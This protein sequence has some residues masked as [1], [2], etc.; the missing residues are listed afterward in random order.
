MKQRKNNRF[1][2]MLMAMLMIVS[3]V[4]TGWYPVVAKADTNT[5][6]TLTVI[7]DTGNHSKNL[8]EHTG[9]VYWL[10]D[11][12]LNIDVNSLE[13]YYVAENCK[14][15]IKAALKEAKIDYHFSDEGSCFPDDMK[16]KDG[17][18]LQSDWSKGYWSVIVQYADGSFNSNG[19]SSYDGAAQLQDGCR[20][21]YY[22]SDNPTNDCRLTT[23]DS[24]NT[25]LNYDTDAVTGLRFSTEEQPDAALTEIE[26]EVGS[27]IDLLTS[28]TAPAQTTVSKALNWTSSN[29]DVATVTASETG[30][31]VTPKSAGTTTVKASM[32]NT[33]GDTVEASCDVKVTSNGTT[34][35]DL[36]FAEGTEISMAPGAV[37]TL[38][39]AYTPE[40]E[41]GETAPALTW[42]SS[43]K[44][45]AD[46]NAQN[47]EITAKTPGTT[48]IKASFTN[49]KGTVVSAECKVTVE[50]IAVTKIAL[51][52]ESLSL[53][54]DAESKLNVTFEPANATEDLDVKWE[55]DDKNVATVT[56]EGKSATV[57][58]VGAGSATITV[59]AGTFKASCEVT[60][61]AAQPMVKEF[62]FA[63]DKNGENVY[64]MQSE[65]DAKTKECT[66]V[67]PETV[68]TFYLKP[69]L[70]DDAEVNTIT[71]NYKN[72]NYTKDLTK[73]MP[74][75]EFTQFSGVN[76]VLQSDI[77]ARE[78]SIDVTSKT[79]KTETYKV[80]IIRETTLSGL[81]VTKADGTKVTLDPVF[82][83]RK[84]EYTI[85]VPKTLESVVFKA[86]ARTAANSEIKVNGKTAE[87]G[88]Y[89]LALTGDDAKVVTE[90]EVGNENTVAGKYTVSI[91]R[92]EPVTITF[93]TEPKDAIITV[94]DK[95][96]IKAGGEDG[97]YKVLP[98]TYTYTV[99]K[100]GYVTKHEEITVEKDTVIKA[101][102]E[103]AQSSNLKDLDCDWAGFRK[104]GSNQAVTSAK[105]AATPETA[106]QK[107]EKKVGE[108]F[109]NWAVSSPIIVDNNL[110]CYAGKQL[111][112]INKETG[113]I[114]ASAPMAGNSSFGINPPCYGGGMIFVGL[115]GGAV[116]AFNAETLESLWVFKD[117]LGGQPNCTI[118]YSDGYIYTGFWNSETKDANFVCVSAT[119][120]DP[121]NTTETKY[122]TWTYAVQGG[123]Y[124][125]GAYVTDKYAIVGSDDGE[126]DSTSDS[127][128]VY[129]FDKL[130]GEVVQK[131]GP[132]HGDIRS[133]I[134]YYDGRIYF[135]S[136]GG[137]LYSYNLKEDGTIDTENLI[138]PIEIGKMST[139]TPAIANG[140][141]Y[142]GS[143]YGSN[144]SGTYGISVVDINAETGAM[145]LE[146]VVYTDAY[147]QTSGVVSTGYK[148]YNYVYF[149][150]N[151]PSGNLWV[152]KDAP[153]M[154]EP[155]EGSQ[156]LYTP[157]HKQ[158]C[159][160]SVAVDKDGTIYFKNDSAYMIAVG[161]SAIDTDKL[162]DLIETAKATDASKYT[163]ESYNALQD[164][165]AEAEA[166]AENPES[167]EQVAEMTEK[168]QSA[169]DGLVVK[170][171]WQ[172]I[173]GKKYYYKEDGIQATY[174]YKVDG[175]YYWF[176]TDGIMKTYWQKV[177]NKYY[178]LGSDGAMRTGWQTVYGK[179]YYLG[180]ANDG[181]M[182]TGWQTVDGK[183]YYLGNASDGAMKTGWQTIDGKKYYLGNDGAM[184]TYWQSVDGKYYWFGTDGVMKTYWQKVYNK[185]YWLG[186]DGAMRTGWQKVYGKYYW[187]GHSNDGAMKTGWQ[188]IYGKKYYFGGANDG[189]MKTGWQKIGG[190]WYYFG[191]ANDGAMKTNT[192]IGN[193]YVNASGVRTRSR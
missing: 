104:D 32:V 57:K 22:W 74:A 157:E 144:F 121:D 154:T 53:K 148:G 166:V 103:K 170:T 66:V 135:T 146:Y 75:N 122:A 86:T 65:L 137:Y 79:G 68:N 179:K 5:G 112:K 30:A 59:T 150:T 180:N 169:I 17:V 61:S 48:V 174:W 73:A 120:E 111:L 95:D 9:Y 186:S 62:V 136:K 167:K 185:Y 7:G 115:A 96:K 16:N 2:A 11:Q 133:D 187:L 44:G 145:K 40:L 192:W 114:I 84:K 110:Y 183:K 85:V 190:N 158:Y 171:G 70:S 128:Y 29:Q 188:T 88:E 90:I 43:D 113:D 151:G 175:N 127:S 189:V 124:W 50:Q 106:F 21:I 99:S 51:D 49:N 24:W 27:D 39:P 56:G 191:G 142:V 34:V 8:D 140:R 117:T 92:E 149:A 100:T 132:H 168:L 3:T 89:T 69:V 47:G 63:S 176:G 36:S 23:D 123:F 108:G 35:T 130:T 67:V 64:A 125:A 165:I 101:S 4:A 156:I 161:N 152:V 82:N 83:A 134:S 19:W 93:E 45:V 78:M 139:S 155:D 41:K 147:P 109:S 81:N 102:L 37:K 38:T 26:T 33:L 138:E 126:S 12:P 28:F 25:Q 76:R 163:D 58:A 15:Q 160:S 94:I 91:L 97:I 159:I 131:V 98:G 116:Q 13:S 72:Y 153:G 20:L 31:V 141:C 77:E 71:A 60:V 80:H 182:K 143:S 55:S 105:T 118:Q 173:D 1:L 14:D 184:K 181:A 172:T 177:Y 54:E 42:E 46:V 178:W 107:W 119:D 18:D 10:K 162:Q 193:Y 164:V 129:C 6:I 87:N 52:K